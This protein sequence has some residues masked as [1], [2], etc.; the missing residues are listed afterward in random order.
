M[1]DAEIA[2]DFSKDYFRNVRSKYFFA[3]LIHL[4]EDLGFEFRIKG[5]HHIFFKKGTEE[6][7]NLQA[8]GKNGKTLPGKTG[9]K[10]NCQIQTFQFFRMSKFEIIIFWSKEDKR[11]LAEVPELPGCMADGKTYSEALQNA[12]EIM[13]EWIETAKSLGREIPEPK[14]KLRYA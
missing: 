5:S 2:K 8:D 6:I 14:G 10:L 12:E 11:F 9:K 3:D 1:V 13:D 7:I 4:L